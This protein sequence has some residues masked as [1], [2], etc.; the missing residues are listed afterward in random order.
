M[1]EVEANHKGCVVPRYFMFLMQA[2]AELF[3]HTCAF[4]L[5]TIFMDHSECCV[6][7]GNWIVILHH[8]TYPTKKKKIK[9][10]NHSVYTQAEYLCM[11]LEHV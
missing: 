5:Y 4:L 7:S 8:F 6:K 9:E 3:E 2:L 11:D 10:K 1:L